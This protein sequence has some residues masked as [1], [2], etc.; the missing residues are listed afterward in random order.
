MKS[1][2]TLLLCDTIIQNREYEIH[3]RIMKLLIRCALNKKLHQ[4]SK[5]RITRLQKKIYEQ[6]ERTTV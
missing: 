3:A 4:Y 6:F 2:L 1:N 5:I